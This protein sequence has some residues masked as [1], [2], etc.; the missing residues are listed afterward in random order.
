MLGGLPCII[1]IPL[2]MFYFGWFPYEVSLWG[3]VGDLTHVATTQGLVATS[4]FSPV[5]CEHI[6]ICY[7]RGKRAILSFSLR[8]PRSEEQNCHQYAAYWRIWGAQEV[9][10]Q[11][12]LHHS[13]HQKAWTSVWSP[14]L[15]YLNPFYL[16][17]SIHSWG[18]AFTEANI[19]FP[20]LS[21]EE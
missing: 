8:C 16:N 14:K 3:S 21:E 18:G 20:S 10:F 19:S 5:L 2:L 13:L 12:L 7:P 6:H 17:A 1:S 9:P 4:H 11:S 15:L